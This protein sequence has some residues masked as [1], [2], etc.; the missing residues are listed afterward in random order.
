M[1][2]IGTTATEP[3]QRSLFIGDDEDDVEDHVYRRCQIHKKRMRTLEAQRGESEWFEC[4]GGPRHG[5]HRTRYWEVF[6]SR[7][8]VVLYREC[9]SAKDSGVTE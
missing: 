6:N 2:S 9:S 3:E 7:T 8:G 1:S 4:P 5:P